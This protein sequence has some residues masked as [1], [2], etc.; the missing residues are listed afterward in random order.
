MLATVDGQ[1][2]AQ[3][4]EETGQELDPAALELYRLAWDLS[5]VAGYLDVFRAPHERTEDTAQ[6]W[7]YLTQ[8]T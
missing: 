6:A 3:Y 7:G 5:D 8:M 2:A 1:E 4:V